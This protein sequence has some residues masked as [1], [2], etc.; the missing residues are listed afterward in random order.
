MRR[1]HGVQSHTSEP[2]ALSTKE[3]TPPEDETANLSITHW[4][5]KK[6]STNATSGMSSILKG[7]NER[8]GKPR[9]GDTVTQSST[10]STGYRDAVRNNQPDQAGIIKRARS[11]SRSQCNSRER[12]TN[13]S[14][15]RARNQTG[16]ERRQAATRGPH[17]RDEYGGT[18]QQHGKGVGC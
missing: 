8:Q 14:L 17:R 9:P 6:R 16:S 1:Q 12:P 15:S 7:S 2:D 3:N 5:L 10:L 18:R 4:F 11:L 13:W